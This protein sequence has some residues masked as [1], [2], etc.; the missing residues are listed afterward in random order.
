VTEF[1]A[2]LGY[3]LI[4]A[5]FIVIAVILVVKTIRLIFEIYYSKNIRYLKVTLPKADS[6]LDKERETKKDFKEKIGMMSMFYKAIHKLSEAGLRDTLLNMLFGHS[7]ISLELVYKEGEVNFFITTYE[8]YVDLVSQHITSIYT[9]AEVRP[10][11]FKDYI[12][13]KPKGYSIR[14]ASLGKE[15]DDVYPIK[16]FKYLE[17]DPLNNFSNVFGGLDRDDRAIFQVVIKP[18]SSRWNVK[19]RKAAGLVSKGKYKKKKKLPFLDF[20]WNPIVALIEG[21]ED[22]VGGNNAP[23]ASEGDAYKIFNQAETEA[24]KVM[25]EAASQPAF[26]TSIRVLVSSKV[27]KK[28]EQ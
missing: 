1:F 21:P 5:L 4:V 3:Y 7:K 13:L 28:A 25:G 26:R 12:D 9:D 20:L 18:I 27:H 2:N 6:K 14:A 24:Q 8:T 22:M 10:V 11:E 16:I 15:N 23:G 19:A 17:D